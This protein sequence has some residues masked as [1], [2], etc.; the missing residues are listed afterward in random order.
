MENLNIAASDEFPAINF[1]VSS[2]YL[3]IDGTCKSYSG[4]NYEFFMPLVAWIKEY[5]AEPA[6][7]T[8]MDVKLDYFGTEVSKFLF[9]MFRELQKIKTNEN[10]PVI[11]WYF[12]ENNTDIFEIGEEYKSLLKLPFNLILLDKQ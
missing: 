9:M 11:N 1:D 6:K 2:G 12:E 10:Q 8:V 7:K 5:A 4:L 3:S